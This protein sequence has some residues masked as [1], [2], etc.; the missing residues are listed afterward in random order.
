MNRICNKCERRPW[1][2]DPGKPGDR[3]LW[4]ECDDGVLVSTKREFY[5]FDP[6][7]IGHAKASWARR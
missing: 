4:R 5:P 7:P 2:F 1:A 6:Y 3:C